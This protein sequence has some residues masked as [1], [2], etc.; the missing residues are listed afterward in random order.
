MVRESPTTFYRVLDR[1]EFGAKIKV[2][3]VRGKELVKLEAEL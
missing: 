1:L 3:L 2:T